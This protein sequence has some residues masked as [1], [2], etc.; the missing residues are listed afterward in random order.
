MAKSQAVQTVAAPVN[1]LANNSEVAVL[2]KGVDVILD[3]F[4]EAFDRFVTIGGTVNELREKGGYTLKQIST[5]IESRRLERLEAAKKSGNVRDMAAMA[6][7]KVGV[8]ETNL[9]KY[10]TIHSLLIHKGGVLEQ[11]RV[12]VSYA[13]MAPLGMSVDDLYTLANRMRDG[14]V[15]LVTVQKALKEETDEKRKAALK[16]LV[17]SS[18]TPGKGKKIMVSAETYKRFM[19]LAKASGHET[20]EEVEQFLN[21]L[22]DDAAKAI[23]PEQKKAA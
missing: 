8:S 2:I 21:V 22:L 4:T 7:A 10:A 11:G 15:K 13:D 14:K 12:K 16:A 6:Q 3:S 19:E 5:R 17:K 9:S 23:K 18:G 20:A 1:V